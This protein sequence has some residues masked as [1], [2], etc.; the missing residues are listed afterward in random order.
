MNEL[1]VGKTYEF[2]VLDLV[3]N[4]V[5]AKK[6]QLRYGDRATYRCAPYPFQVENLPQVVYCKVV[7]IDPFNGLP[8]AADQQCGFICRKAKVIQTILPVCAQH[9]L[10]HR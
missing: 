5:G 9:F 6:L 4:S 7:K 10:T 3:E 2:E 8:S 1:Q